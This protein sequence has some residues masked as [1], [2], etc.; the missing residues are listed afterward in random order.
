MPTGTP[1]TQGSAAND[2]SLVLLVDVRGV[3]ILM[4]GD[5]EPAAQQRHEAPA[6]ELAR[7]HGEVKELGEGREDVEQADEGALARADR[8]VPQEAVARQGSG[9]ARSEVVEPVFL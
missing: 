6:V 8:H 9:G 1:E 4:A 2:A 7:G 3:R 5:M